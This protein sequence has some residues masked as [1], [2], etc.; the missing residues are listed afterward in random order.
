MTWFLVLAGVLAACAGAGRD[1]VRPDADSL[2]LGQ[3][4]YAQVVQK[5]GEPK[6]VSDALRNGKQVKSI[7]YSYA[8]TH[9]QP[10]EEGVTPYRGMT[11]SFYNDTL[12]GE[13]FV[14][15]FKSDNSNFDD[16]LVDRVKKGQTT[17]QEVIQLF[18]APSAAFIPPMIKEA[19]GD[20]IGYTYQAI[21][22]G[23]F[24]GLKPYV[25]ALRISFDASGI[26]TDVEYSSQGP[27]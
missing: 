1:F 22:G 17:R 19:S 5:M 14:S 15:S 21:R 9:G 25:K 4:T 24:S 2:K 26:V 16:T 20:G 6:T 8:N 10:L 3:T 12:V 13:Q 23:L 27:R 7:V 11:Y 18:G